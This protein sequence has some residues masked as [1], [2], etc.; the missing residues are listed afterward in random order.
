MNSEDYSLHTRKR[1]R[2]ILLEMLYIS[3]TF[4]D[5]LVCPFFPPL[6]LKKSCVC[7]FSAV[8]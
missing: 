6:L 7:L 1:I 2:N 3:V 4:S 5:L 8:K